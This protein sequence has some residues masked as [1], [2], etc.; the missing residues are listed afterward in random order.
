M[1]IRDYLDRIADFCGRKNWAD[2]SA[3]EERT[4]TN[5]FAEIDQDAYMRALEEN[6]CY[7]ESDIE[8][9]RQEGYNDGYEDGCRDTK[10]ELEGSSEND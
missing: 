8:E 4:L 5:I 3:E 1:Q 10:E 2:F 7:D 6:Q 9:A